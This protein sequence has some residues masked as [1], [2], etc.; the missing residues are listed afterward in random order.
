MNEM[1]IRR[2]PEVVGAEIRSLTTQAKCIT[3]WYGIEIGR[4]LCEAKEL[5]E[6]G[7]WLNFLERETEFSQPSASRFM[8]LYNEYGAE[9]GSLFGA[10]SKYSTLNNLSISNALRLLE[11]PEN[12]REEFARK[13]DAEHISSREL[14]RLI[15]E[16]KEAERQLQ[17]AEEGHALAMA[18]LQTQLDEA[19]ERAKEAEKEAAQAKRREAEGIAP[20]EERI[21]VLEQENKELSERPVEVAVQVDEKAVQEA[22]TAA[23]AKSDAEWSGKFAEL[24]N[25]DADKERRIGGLEKQLEK[26]KTKLK[27]AEERAAEDAGPYKEE[28]ERLKKQ[29]ALSNAE[30]TVFNIHFSAVQES[31][32]KLLASLEKVKQTD[33]E[34][35][36][37]LEKA[38]RAV[39]GQFQG[40]IGPG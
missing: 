2:T 30:V 4:R 19:E 28:V 33:A 17:D 14:E 11:L 16:K 7:E 3:L 10:E 26:A 18:E 15:R 29:L 27:A 40:R 21:R 34:T 39:L 22:A 32:N 6:H 38:L 31:F 1:E 35:A 13:H 8:R 20:Y 12:E 25:Q 9:Q 24:K 5:V 23:R 37:K 36:G